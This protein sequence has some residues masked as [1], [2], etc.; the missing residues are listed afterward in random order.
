MVD[1]PMGFACGWVWVMGYC[2]PMGYGTQFPVNQG[3][4]QLELWVSRG[5]GLSEVWI[6]RGSTV[7]A[8][9]Y[10]DMF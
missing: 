10:T 4:G 2:G 3:G 6:T 8:S 7:Y 5:Y 9:G 1:K